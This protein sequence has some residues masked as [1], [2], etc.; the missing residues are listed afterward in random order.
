MHRSVGPGVLW[1]VSLFSLGL[2]DI[3]AGGLTGE[4][5]GPSLKVQP[6]G[7]GSAPPDSAKEL[8]VLW[9]RRADLLTSPT[10]ARRS[11]S[12]ERL[13]KPCCSL[14]MA[15]LWTPHCL[16]SLSRC[17]WGL[18]EGQREDKYY[19]DHSAPLFCY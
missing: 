13:R 3:Q 18:G 19:P 5:E 4:R 1:E 8:A 14:C 7:G 17:V 16:N 10:D 15:P 2:S 9:K 11:L 6:A 12:R